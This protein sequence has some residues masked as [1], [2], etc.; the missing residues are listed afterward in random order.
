MRNVSELWSD[1]LDVP[2][3]VEATLGHAAGFDVAS[4]LL[5]DPDVNRVVV[6]GN[7]ASYY[8]ALALWI[9]SLSVP[10]GPT[11]VALP[12]GL[13]EPSLRGFGEADRLVV[14]SSSGE[15]RDALDATRRHATKPFILIPANPES[16]LGR[17]ASGLV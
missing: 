1:V 7:G 3:A 6:A 8:V 10:S 5:S 15:L 4:Q 12:A 11:I 13:L 14:V 2:L 17:S 9:S 16:S